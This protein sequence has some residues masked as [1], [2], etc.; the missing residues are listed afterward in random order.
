V[1]D[2]RRNLGGRGAHVCPTRRCIE[3]AVG[4]HGF[5]RALKSPVKYPRVEVLLEAARGAV[6]R[7]I[8]T[9]V[10]SAASSGSLAT[11]TDATRRSM[12]DGSAA[13][14]VVAADARSRSKLVREAAAAG[15]S[16][17][18]LATKDRIGKM[19]GRRPTGVLA[20]EDQGLAAALSDALDR[21][22]ALQG[23]SPKAD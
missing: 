20:I 23:P 15:I 21:L 17:R 2:W 12:M 11:G 22:D 19:T 14:L 8:E 3:R 4:R 6:S 7:Q 16:C 1:F 10:W 13:C 9:L 5:D 18:T